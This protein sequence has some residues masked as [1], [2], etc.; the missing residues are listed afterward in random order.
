MIEYGW[1]NRTHSLTAR[2]LWRKDEGAKGCPS[3]MPKGKR[4][5]GGASRCVYKAACEPRRS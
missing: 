1:T 3:I 5:D 2:L 4:C